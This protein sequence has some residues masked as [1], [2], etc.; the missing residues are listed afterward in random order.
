MRKINSLLFILL[1]LLI[2]TVSCSEKDE[3]QIP[4]NSDEKTINTVSQFVYDGLSAYYLWSDDMINKKPSINDKDPEKYFESLLFKTDTDNG[5]S[6]ITDDAKGLKGDFAGEPESLSFG[7][8]LSFIQTRDNSIF[9]FIKYVYANTPASN[10]GLQRLDLIRE[11][12]G[13]PITTE[14]GTNLISERDINLLYGNNA[15]TFT[16]YKLTDEGIIFNKEMKI[17]PSTIKTDPI[18]FDKVYNVG[19]KKI[20]YLFYTDFISNYNNRLFEVFSKFKTE[21]V[22]DLVLD[23]RYNLGGGI[24]AASYLVSLF[25]SEASLKEKTILTTL[26]YNEF[27]N[28]YYDN[29]NWSRSYKLGDYQ[30]KDEYDKEGNIKYKAAPN[31]LGANLDLSKVY[32]IATKNSASASELIT[33]C[34]RPIMG[35]LNVIH[36]GDT[37]RGK[38]TASFTVHPYD[39][40]IGNTT[41]SERGL[42]TKEKNILKNWAMQPIVAIYKDKN[43]KDFL[44]PGYLKPDYLLKEGFGYI[45]NWKPIGDPKD[46]FFGQALYLITGDESYKPIEPIST[47]ALNVKREIIELPTRID[48]AKPLIIDNMRLTP[49]DFKEIT[50]MRNSNN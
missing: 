26:S 14:I 2:V 37:T 27:L 36:I 34:S 41:Y 9:A 29:K 32:I 24:D 11:I 20:G 45:E 8:S 17:A 46:V 31:P 50:R 4:P 42:S 13:Q 1:A 35:E 22:T 15:A 18:L 30:E 23:L 43:G 5:W 39:K 48:D 10:A 7:Y 47:R 38:Y 16:V 25:T 40:E 12:N 44:N 21:G 33:F 49:E 6:W 28:K 3:L 19:D